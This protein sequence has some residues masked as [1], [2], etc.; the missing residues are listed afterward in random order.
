MYLY[1]TR[2][3]CKETGGL[4]LGPAPFY[5]DR[6]EGCIEEGCP[7][8]WARITNGRRTIVIAARGRSQ[9][10]SQLGTFEQGEI[11]YNRQIQVQGILCLVVYN[12]NSGCTLAV[13]VPSGG[14]YLNPLSNRRR[15]TWPKRWQHA[16]VS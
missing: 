12:A 11:S 16:W 15:Q 7:G 6:S 5:A 8:L 3:Q 4:T 2:R 13:G 10:I 9:S 1:T 14:I